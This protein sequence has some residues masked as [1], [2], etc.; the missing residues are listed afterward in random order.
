MVPTT[1]APAVRANV[2]SSLSESSTLHKLSLSSCS[3]AT[4]KA[5]SCLP[6]EPLSKR[7][8]FGVI[9][10]RVGTRLIASV[11]FLLLLYHLQCLYFRERGQGLDDKAIHT[12][13]Q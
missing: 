13:K 4:R 5:C 2:P 7:R 11:Y 6:R 3:T 12:G 9:P 10:L 1:S 8:C